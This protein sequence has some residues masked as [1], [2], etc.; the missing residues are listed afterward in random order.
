MA[1]VCKQ[2]SNGKLNG[3]KS[4]QFK[5]HDGK[6]KTLRL[7]KVSMKTAEGVR[8]QVEHLLA[9]RITKHS[10]DRSTAQW[11]TEIEPELRNRLVSVGLIDARESTRLEDY[12]EAYYKMRETDT[13]P[14]TQK[15]YR[16]AL[17]Y[18]YEFFTREKLLKDI[19]PGDCDEWRL[20]L[21]Q[22]KLAENTVRKHCAVAK[23]FFNNA[24]RR[25]L[26]EENPFQDLKATSVP[27]K[28]REYFITAEETEKVLTACPD[29]EWRLIVA[30]ARY[31]GLRIPSEPYALRWSDINWADDRFYV[32]SPKTEHHEGKEGR[33]VPLFPQLRPYL[34]DCRELA[35]DDAEFVIVKHRH[36]S[37]N[38]RTTMQK[39]VKRAGLNQWPRLFQNLRSSRE[40][41]LLSEGF[42]LQTVVAWLGNSA[43]V[44]LKN[45]LQVRE[46]DYKKATQ[47]TAQYT[48][49]SRGAVG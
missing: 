6:R 46:D 48:T 35:E 27:N 33:M 43:V 30:L 45:Y 22:K 5:G 8:A 23:V 34:E 15:K 40:T 14:N 24:V 44:A 19:T 42:Q 16:N 12:C 20:W 32:S 49:V 25:K 31:G 3:R 13:K 21:V 7:G 2:S 4:I 18:I 37:C 9:H 38:L 47:N 29:A 17:N 36:G 10:L 39:I 28:S 26:I 41:E 1:S 11:L